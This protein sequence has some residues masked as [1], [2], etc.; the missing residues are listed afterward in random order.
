MLYSILTFTIGYFSLSSN[1]WV[2]LKPYRFFVLRLII[3]YLKLSCFQSI[4]HSV[5]DNHRWF[6][7]HLN[8]AIL[9]Y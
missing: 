9:I 2:K 1:F 6:F 4:Y 7:I 3:W 8:N 5:T